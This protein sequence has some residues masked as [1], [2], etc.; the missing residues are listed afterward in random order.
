MAVLITIVTVLIAVAVIAWFITNRKNPARSDRAPDH[1]LVTDSD[2]FY[3]GTDRPAGPDAEPMDPEVM[4]G[5]ISD[6][7]Q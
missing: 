3:A 2:R 7:S 4:L 6:P 5:H 1:P